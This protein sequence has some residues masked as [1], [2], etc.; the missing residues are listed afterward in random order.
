MR[1]HRCRAC[2]KRGHNRA[3]CTKPRYP[4]KYYYRGRWRSDNPDDDEP[5]DNQYHGLDEYILKHVGRIG[6]TS[7][8]LYERVTADYGL[9]GKRTFLRHLRALRNAKRL[10]ATERPFAQGYLYTRRSTA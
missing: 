10:M 5:I 3:T 6:S 8:E 1:V 4:G 2:L 7:R 9:V